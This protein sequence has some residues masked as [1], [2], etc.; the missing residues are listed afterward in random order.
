MTFSKKYNFLFFIPLCAVVLYLLSPFKFNTWHPILQDVEK[1]YMGVFFTCILLTLL[2]SKTYFNKEKFHFSK[3]DVLLLA[4]VLYLLAHT[5]L[6]KPTQQD[7][8]FILE[9]FL[10]IVL[11]ICFRSIQKEWLLYFFW[12]VVLASFFHIVYGISKQTMWFAPGYGLSDI[13]GSFINQAP[14][15]CSIACTWFILLMLFKKNTSNQCNRLNKLFINLIY[16]TFL[17]IL[18]LVIVFSDSRATWL[19]GIVTLL[20][21]FWQ[22]YG[23]V[24]WKRIGK[25][26]RW[27][28]QLSIIAILC[29]FTF[30]FYSLYHYKKDSA[31]GRLLIWKIS[32]NM[33]LDHPLTGHGV[34]SFQSNYMLYQGLYFENN[35]NDVDAY[36]ASDNRYAFNEIIRIAVEEGIIGILIVLFFGFIFFNKVCSLNVF[37][38]KNYLEHI[39]IIGLMVI[40]IFG[41]FS[42][43]LEIFYLKILIILFLSVIANYSSKIKFSPSII[44][45]RRA[46]TKFYKVSIFI[47]SLILIS[48]SWLKTTKMLRTYKSWNNSL[49]ELRNGNYKDYLLFCNR[50]YP[51]LKKDG[52]FLTLYGKS[53]TSVGKYKKSIQILEQAVRISPSSTIYVDLGISYEGLGNYEKAEECWLKA[54]NMVPSQFNPKFLIAKMYQNNGQ[55]VKAKKIAN[56]LLNNKKI[57][58]HSIEVYQILEE[59]KKIAE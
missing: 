36:L 53:L 37:R 17:A 50:E 22:N 32:K 20:F 51:M 35:P 6:I 24:L 43:P 29:I 44:P 26:K 15:G 9:N 2:V 4:Y 30:S 45:K 7:Y 8:A 34:N 12:I 52:D 16:L 55:T 38:S 28:T 31:N 19:A 41:M 46:N 5:L 57:K 33:I 58:I 13:R 23:H 14:F 56:D 10:L 25:G 48:F 3:V 49:F 11:Y 1:I 21:F 40:F 47:L 39:S 42:Y 18:F 27:I 54:S 59:L